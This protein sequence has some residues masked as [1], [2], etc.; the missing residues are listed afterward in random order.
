V[1][2]ERVLTELGLAGAAYAA[3]VGGG[4]GAGFRVDEPMTPASVMKIQIGLAVEN[5]IA[6]GSLD[7]AAQR[8]LVAARRTP[9]PVG[10]SLMRDDVSMSVRDLNVAMLTISDNV[11][12]DEPTFAALSAHD[13]NAGPPSEPEVARRLAGCA[14]LDPARGTRTT[15]AESVT[16][17]QAIWTDRAGPPR[18]CATIRATMGRQ[19]TR[20]RIASGFAAPIT[21]AAKSGALLGVARNEAGVVTFPDGAAYAVA[22]FTRARATVTSDPDSRDAG[23]G[24]V[25]RI[26]VDQLRAG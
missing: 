7:G 16:L 19:L 6:D 8:L 11:A 2:A 4:A 17:L 21:V 25:A 9:G 10:I 18:A 3:P 22:V 15:A 5:A 26:L 12:T 13:P 23:I 14:P 20:N 24:P 1:E